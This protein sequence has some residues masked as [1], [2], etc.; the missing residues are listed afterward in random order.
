MALCELHYFSPALCK[1]TAAMVILPE[2]D[3]RPPYAVM[4]LL[5]GLSDDHTIWQR[6]TSIERYV[7]DYPLI[8]VMPD[9]GRGFYTDAKEGDAWET[10]LVR[11][12]IG[13]VDTRFQT[14]ASRAGRCIGGLSMGGY[15]AVKLALKHPGLFCSAVSH[16][17]AL[18]RA[19]RSVLSDPDNPFAAELRRIF[20]ED[21][22]GGPEDLFTLAERLQPA[23]RPALRIDCGTDDFLL[24]DNRGFHAHLEKL[25][26]PHEYAEFP[27]G[28]DWG[29]WDLHVQ[30]AIA[31]HARHLGLERREA[32][33]VDV[34]K[35]E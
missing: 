15:G 30:E 5:H 4:Y 8:V 14:R 16:S 34:T 3:F 11:D 18:G 1:Q 9:G 10:A 6:R 20:G 31:F 13:F 23:K 32:P 33:G 19:H 35:K 7:A 28:H 17:G 24:E 26:Y 2:G 27:G 22:T 29:Y 12:L 25:G 21:P